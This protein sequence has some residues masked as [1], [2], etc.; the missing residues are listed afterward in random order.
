MF[1]SSVLLAA[2]VAPF[3]GRFADGAGSWSVFAW[4]SGASF[5]TTALLAAAVGLSLPVVVVA[6]VV[7]NCCFYLAS[8]LYDSLLSRVAPADRRISYSGFAWGFG[9]LGG[10]ACFG[11]VYAIQTATGIASRWPYLF[12]ALFYTVFGVLAV[13]GLKTHIVGAVRS[14]RLGLSDMLALLDRPRR[15]LLFGYWLITECVNTI[16][17][18]TAI[19]GATV[20]GLSAETIGAYL[21]LV[22]LLAFP[23]TYFVSTL[24]T[25]IGI[26]R[27]LFAC[28]GVWLVI[29]CLMAARVQGPGFAVL[30]CLTSLV[31]GS[32]QALMRAQYANFLSVER[33]SEGFGWYAIS[34]ESSA[35]VAPVVFGGLAALLKSEQLALLGLI[36]PLIVGMLISNT[37]ARSL[38]GSGAAPTR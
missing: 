31:I 16:I 10:I 15:T 36:V 8:N 34:T 13:H 12:L 17:V 38:E 25:R 30:A 19:I 11:G 32:T 33:A 35:V 9:Y 29:I 6:F 2:M 21:L 5:L 27:T 37:A 28:I 4:I 18:F 22:Q 14:L 24:A 3:L 20:Y 23:A 26:R 1:G 7:S